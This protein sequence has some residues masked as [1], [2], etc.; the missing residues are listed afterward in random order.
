[1][2]LRVKINSVGLLS[3]YLTSDTQFGYVAAVGDVRDVEVV[4]VAVTDGEAGVLEELPR[5]QSLRI[6]HS[7]ISDNALRRCSFGKRA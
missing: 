1:M 2:A 7:T 6:S 4:S 5:L 3:S